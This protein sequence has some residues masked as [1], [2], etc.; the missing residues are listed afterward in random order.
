MSISSWKNIII[1]EYWDQLSNISKILNDF[2]QMQCFLLSSSVAIWMTYISVSEICQTFRHVMR[3]LSEWQM[4]CLNS[5]MDIH[6]MPGNLSEDWNTTWESTSLMRSVVP[7]AGIKAGTS[8]SL[9]QILWDV[10][11]CPCP[12]Y[13]LLAQ[14]SSHRVHPTKYIIVHGSSFVVYCISLV[15]ITCILQGYFIG[16]GAIILLP[17]CQWSN[18]E[19]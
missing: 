12:W 7:E 14:H 16:T 4:I 3:R 19:E 6:A 9:P 8:N 11:T 13:L 17:Q 18:P 10:I 1:L 15:V 2:M 5:Y